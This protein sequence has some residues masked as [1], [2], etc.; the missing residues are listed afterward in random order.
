M[1][2]IN[3]ASN[4]KETKKQKQQQKKTKK[5]QQHTCEMRGVATLTL[6]FADECCGREKSE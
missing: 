3:D 2:V 6:R 1:S 4:K 5:N